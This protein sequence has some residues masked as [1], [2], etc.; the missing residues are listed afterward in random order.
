MRRFA[1]FEVQQLERQASAFPDDVPEI[2]EE[3]HSHRN[4]Q[5]AQS[6]LQRLQAGIVKGTEL[7]T[8]NLGE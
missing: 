7:E 6:L 1:H 5:E 2:I 8:V 4:S 3:L